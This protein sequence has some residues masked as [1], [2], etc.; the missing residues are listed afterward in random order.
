MDFFRGAGVRHK[1]LGSRASSLQQ[2]VEGRGTII[3]RSS[4][5]GPIRPRTLRAPRDGAT[6]PDSLP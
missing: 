5:N 2:Q 4:P 3:G 1:A 6:Q